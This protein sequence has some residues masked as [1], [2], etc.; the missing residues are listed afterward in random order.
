M[1][2]HKDL[3]SKQSVEYSKFRPA[4]PATV[5]AYL[6]GLP[7]ARDCVWDCGTGNGQ[8]A[9]ELARHFKQVVATDLSQKQL[10]SARPHERVTYSVGTAESSGLGDHV[11]DLVTVAQAFHWFKHEQFYAEVRR[12][13]RPEGAVLAI[14]S[15][16]LAFITPEVD[17]VVSHFYND[18]VGPYWEAERRF[19]E[20]GY[21]DI[22]V[23]FREI[24]PVPA[25][26]MRVEWT[27]EHLVGYLGT[28]SATQSAIKKLGRNPLDEVVE[29]LRG[30]WGAETTRTVRWPLAVRAFEIG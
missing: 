4:Y 29:D 30:A 12:V 19:V 10:D 16:A 7:R 28:W 5:F 15:Y 17:R 25:F 27:L 11:A 2:S 21:G 3:F 23:P 6:A 26:D 14:W 8:A 24:K 1:S 20:S 18:V 9:L 13:A 22:D